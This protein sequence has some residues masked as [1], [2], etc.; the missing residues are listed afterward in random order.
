MKGNTMKF[1]LSL[2]ILCATNRGIT[3]ESKTLVGLYAHDLKPK[4]GIPLAGYGSKQRRMP[5][6]IDWR[7][8]YPDATFFRPSEGHHSAI[9]SKVMAFKNGDN[10]LVFLSLDTIG[11]EDRFVKDL[12]KNLSHLGIKEHELIVSATH[13]HGGPGTLSKRIPLQAIAVDLY[14][15]KNYKYILKEVVYSVEQ[16]MQN[17]RPVELFKTK[18]IIEGVQK[19][20][21]RLKDQE[22]F[23]KRASF[24]IARDSQTGSWLGGMVNFSIHGGTM[25]IGLMLYSSDINGAIEIE[26]EKYFAEINT[27]LTAT[28]VFLFL[29]GAEGDVGGNSERSVEAIE[30]LS[31]SFIEQATAD[32]QIDKMQK[33]DQHFSVEKKKIFVGHP[34]LPLRHCQG[35]LLGKAPKWMKISLYKLLPSY[36]Y[37]S[38]AIVGDITYLTW[39]GEPSTQLGYDLQNIATAKGHTDPQIISLTNDYMTYFTTKSEYQEKVYD[40]CSS[41]YSWQGANR[42]LNAFSDWM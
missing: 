29:N 27:P 3:Q 42:I 18:S 15:D 24:L 38:K 5:K 41:M 9:R 33:V 10:N 12:A 21:W 36:S 22:H 32:L 2:I 23:D 20:K 4:V 35:G 25:P 28:P 7:N 34:T 8:R 26:L 13:T 11:T 31:K 39:P 6:F 16:A 37:I 14:K 40:S 1:I 19:N 17:L 30:R